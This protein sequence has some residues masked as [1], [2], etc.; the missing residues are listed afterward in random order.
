MLGENA[1]VESAVETACNAAENFQTAV[2][3]FNEQKKRQ[4]QQ[5]VRELNIGS[6]LFS[7]TTIMPGHNPF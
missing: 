2:R 7:A 4:F 6:D 1:H 5:P 3:K